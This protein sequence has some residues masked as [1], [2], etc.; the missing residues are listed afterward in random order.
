MDQK[1]SSKKEL[2][3]EVVS[4]KMQKTV[5]VKVETKKPHPLYGKIVKRWKNYKAHTESEFEIG[6]RVLIREHKPI[7][8][9][10][11]WIVIEKIEK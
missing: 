2:V 5:V 11:R 3:G 10:K 6:E 7:S 1:K 9:D 4:N 8:K